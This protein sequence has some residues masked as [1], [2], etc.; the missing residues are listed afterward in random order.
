ME[1]VWVD[2]QHQPQ[3]ADVWVSFEGSGLLQCYLIPSPQFSAFAKGDAVDCFQFDV[4]PPEHV[5][6]IPREGLW[7]VVMR[8]GAGVAEVRVSPPARLDANVRAIL[9]PEKYQDPTPDPGA[10][11]LTE[12]LLAG[13]TDWLAGLQ[14]ATDQAVMDQMAKIQEIQRQLDDTVAA[15]YTGGPGGAGF[16]ATNARVNQLRG[17]L[18]MALDALGIIPDYSSIDPKSV[19][20]DPEGLFAFDLTEKGI[21][22][23]VYGEFKN[24]TGK[25]FDQ[26]NLTYYTFA[27]GKLASTN[28]LDS[29]R[30]ITDDALLFNTITA[31]VGAP[32]A[33]A[34]V[35]AGGA[36]AFRGLQ[37]LLSREGADRVT[38][39]TGKKVIAESLAAAERRAAAS[40]PA[41][42]A[43]TAGRK[44]VGPGAWETVN[45]SMSAR[46]A[47][48]QTQIT[49]LPITDGY[50]IRT[51]T[52]PVKFDGF[53]NGVL[54]DA[55]SYYSNF[56]K[57]DDW[58]WFFDTEKNFLRQARSQLAAAGGT[59]IEWVF[60]E[61]KTAALVGQLLKDANLSGIAIKVVLPK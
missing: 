6:Q 23:Q 38:A 22:V 12:A 21:P 56:I 53:H 51:A 59:P 44:A 55:K 15:A 13:P 25:F 60:A 32:A 45:E 1:F 36:G 31:L 41:T 26:T 20:V 28:T 40:A 10:L 30:A 33:F 39:I 14:H 2:L 11:H 4:A 5:V 58:I 19:N 37:A 48:Y 57:G 49:G 8:G 35:K 17:E 46:A 3:G 47:A 54:I 16:D 18:I 50:V 24:G 43:G 7:H 52:G 42:I 34:M 9:Q 27:N 61:P 29:G